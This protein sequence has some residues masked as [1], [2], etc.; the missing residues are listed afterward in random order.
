VARRKTVAV[1]LALAPD[2][3]KFKDAEIVQ[4]R[5]SRKMSADQIK[6]LAAEFHEFLTANAECQ[7]YDELYRLMGENVGD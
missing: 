5:W 4:K 3:N 7:F 6:K 2:E 1:V